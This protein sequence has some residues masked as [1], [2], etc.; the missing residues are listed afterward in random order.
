MPTKALGSD[1]TVGGVSSFLQESRGVLF[2]LA[3]GAV[4]KVNLR[5]EGSVLTCSSR[6]GSGCRE[7]CCCKPLSPSADNTALKTETHCMCKHEI[8]RSAAC[9]RLKIY[10]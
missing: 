8:N 6:E 4:N 1:G 2:N 9:R 10:T 5:K 7:Q 3:V